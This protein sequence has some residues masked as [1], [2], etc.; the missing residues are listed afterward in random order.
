MRI[1]ILKNIERSVAEAVHELATYA[2]VSPLVP[3]KVLLR[4][5]KVYRVL[6]E[7]ESPAHA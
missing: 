6:A 4:G 3:F 1:L 5:C 7:N 2:H